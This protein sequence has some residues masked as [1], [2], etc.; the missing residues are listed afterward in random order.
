MAQYWQR[1][2]HASWRLLRGAVSGRP[3]RR[4]P[5]T[6]VTLLAA[7]ALGV[8]MVVAVH[9]VNRSALEGFTDGVRALAGKSD[10][11]LTATRGSLPE[12]WLARLRELPAVSAAWPALELKLALG[13]GER[14]RVISL[15][16]LDLFN[17]SALRDVSATGAEYTRHGTPT[18]GDSQ[19][20]R[21][22]SGRLSLL[23]GGRRGKAGGVH[24]PQLDSACS[25]AHSGVA[26]W[27]CWLSVMVNRYGI[28]GG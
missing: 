3:W 5:G 15:L 11:T 1:Q 21:S 24:L 22:E 28:D 16:G 20:G 13:Q 7:I 2:G 9:L 4:H 12:L 25:G 18:E 10:L 19:H 26:A 8:A 17:D 23:T 27:N 6:V 14:A